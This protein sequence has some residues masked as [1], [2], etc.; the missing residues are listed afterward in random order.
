MRN[1][2]PFV[3][4][5]EDRVHEGKFLVSP[6]PLPAT[7][8][9]GLFHFGGFMVS[10]HPDGAVLHVDKRLADIIRNFT[11][12]HDRVLSIWPGQGLDKNEQQ[13]AL[14]RLKAESLKFIPKKTAEGQCQP[15]T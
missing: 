10:V 8:N 7:E 6:I 5:E 11:G 4:C 14:E 13:I 2:Y 1:Q 3:T 15:T 12:D 9:P